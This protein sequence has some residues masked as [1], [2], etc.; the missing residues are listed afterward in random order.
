MLNIVVFGS[1]RG[2]NFTS[3]VD[4]IDSGRLRDCRIVL[5]VSNNAEAGILDHARRR[6]IPVLHW[7][8]KMYATDEA[9]CAAMLAALREARADLIVLAGYMKFLPAP[10][11]TA[12]SNRILNI[13]PALLPSFGGTGMYGLHVHRAVLA[14]HEPLTGATVHIVDEEYDHGP[15]VIQRTVPVLASDSPDSLAGRVLEMEHHI[16][17]EAIRLFAEGRIVVE[18]GKTHVHIRSSRE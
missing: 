8:R 14:A 13:H 16:L 5:V 7:S 11:I 3:V 2:S 4:A 12:F 9:Y 15:I 18:P 6:N 17:P 10:I 1:G